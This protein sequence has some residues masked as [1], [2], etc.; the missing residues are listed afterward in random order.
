MFIPA[1]NY[2]QELNCKVNVNL[3]NLPQSNK[4]NLRDFARAVEDYMNKTRF[5]NSSWDVDKIQC[6][7]EIFFMSASGEV[8]YNAQFFI[9]SKRAIYQSESFSPMLTILDNTWSFSYEKNQALNQNQSIFDPLTGFLDF[10][11]YLII[12]FD[13]ES[14]EEFGG[15]PF[16]TKAMDIVNLGASSKF[17]SGWLRSS[18]TYSRRGVVEDLLNERF[19]NFREAFYDYHYGVDI[20]AKNKTI[21]REKIVGLIKTVETI[22][23]KQNVSGPL[24]NTFFDAKHGEI[25]DLLR[26]YPDEDIVRI[27]KRIDPPHA[28]KYETLSEQN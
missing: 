2:A 28:A 14:W 10:Y 9:G 18:S 12:G 13:L 22:K 24:L 16:F 3:E 11:A 6:T 19:R 7:L 15:S 4:D 25:I 20:F 8:T 5:T 26:D 1:F 17:S 27:L 21:G 23:T